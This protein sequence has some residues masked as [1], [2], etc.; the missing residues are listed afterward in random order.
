MKDLLK[1]GFVTM[2]I[3]MI[4]GL[5]VSAF[6]PLIGQAIVTMGFTFM[7]LGMIVELKKFQ[8]LSNN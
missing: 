1:I 2:G 4:I 8:K 7:V 6:K 5:L 3:F